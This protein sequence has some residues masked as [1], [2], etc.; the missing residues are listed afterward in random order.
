MAEIR[1][2][3]IRN[4][5][6]R[7]AWMEGFCWDPE[8][9][10][11]KTEPSAPV[12]RIFFPG[13]DSAKEECTWGHLSFL[14]E[15]PENTVIKLYAF[16]SE[17]NSFY[18]DSYRIVPFDRFFA[19]DEWDSSVKKQLF[20][21]QDYRRFLNQ[22][23]VL[24]YE[25]KGRYLYLFLEILTDREVCL[26][27]IN[28]VL[29]GDNFLASFPEIYQKEGEFF[30]RYLSIYSTMFNDL[31]KK[32]T[33]IPKL[34]DVETA[35]EPLLVLFGKWMR[36]DVSGNFLSEDRLRT[37]IREIYQLNK[38]KGTGKVLKRIAEIVLGE[39][40]ILV[41]KNIA[42]QYVEDEE[43]EAFDILYG[44]GP[45]EAT[46]LI[47]SEVTPNLRA[48]LLFLLDQFKPIRCHLHVVFLD[49]NS[50]MNAHCYLD[51]NAKLHELGAGRMDEKQTMDGAIVLQ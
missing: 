16:A 11:L 36:L 21:Q 22:K 48:Q 7:K 42:S 37:L 15:I 5:R 34:L 23:D 9:E 46:M 20:R 3:G 24:L 41:E 26:K 8:K 32:I 6:I 18:D 10:E 51:V 4:N 14:S 25:L 13:I 40:V 12:H 39:K 38:I 47:R 1:N 50:K 28:I 45:F 44:D 30:H 49:D 27:D 2:Y 33:Q 17:Q 29:P 31:Q 19:S 35:P 43:K